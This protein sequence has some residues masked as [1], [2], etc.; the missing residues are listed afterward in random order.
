MTQHSEQLTRDGDA[1]QDLGAPEP[2]WSP[3]R[4]AVLGAGSWGTTFAKILTDAGLSGEGP[5]PEVVLWGRDAEAMSRIART[6]VNERYVPGTHLP[7]PL[8]VTADLAQALE[9]ADLVVLAVPAQALRA[10]MA[11]VAQHLE[12]EAVLVSLAKGLERG[13]GLRMS[14]VAAEVLAEQ[15]PEGHPL[16]GRDREGWSRRLC[17]VSGP[18]LAMEIA[19]EQPTASVV[20]AADP[21]L[22]AG[23]ARAVAAPYFRPYTNTDAV[24]TE[25]AGLTKNVIALSVGICDGRHYGDNSKA[26]VITRGLAESTR[27][28]LALGARSET[29]A[30]LA[31]IGDLVATCS[32]PLSRNR[33]AGRLLG[34]GRTLEQIDREM[35]QT[36][37]GLKSA[38]AVLQLARAHGVDMPI[39]EAVV[40]ILDGRITVEH[41]APL[42]L[43]RELKAEATTA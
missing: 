38:P 40:A 42:L 5:A 20:A 7:D 32:S 21:Q 3:R 41:L 13:T 31:G 4:A 2:R 37:E 6:R 23:V 9:G 34:Q 24:G 25:I 1:A 30:G 22:A 43:G 26:S 8:Q 12:H 35:T 39:T 33:T 28:A 18:N 16:G 11:A 19:D 29:M 36:A 14:E 15:R 10:Q 17:I 27:L